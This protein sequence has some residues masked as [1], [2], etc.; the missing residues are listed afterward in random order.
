MQAKNTH[1]NDQTVITIATAIPPAC[2]DAALAPWDIPD[3]DE[4]WHIRNWRQH[5]HNLTELVSIR[6]SLLEELKNR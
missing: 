2:F 4:N 5:L 1:L 3:S 6:K